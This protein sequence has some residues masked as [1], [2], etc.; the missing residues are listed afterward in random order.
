MRHQSTSAVTPTSIVTSP[1]HE[2]APTTDTEVMRIWVA[3]PIQ[4]TPRDTTSPQRLRFQA[5]SLEGKRCPRNNPVPRN[6]SPASLGNQTRKPALPAHQPAP[7][8]TQPA[9]LGDL[10]GNEKPWAPPIP[11][12]KGS[13]K[14]ANLR[15]LNA[16]TEL[17]RDRPPGGR[18]A[19]RADARSHATVPTAHRSSHGCNC[20]RSH[21]PRCGTLATH[22]SARVYATRDGAAQSSPDGPR[23]VF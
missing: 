3:R 21:G 11:Q 1:R 7:R 4:K 16:A 13:L 14:R 5:I 6:A 9:S 15:R 12:A 19:Y 20:V 10:A 17:T 2:L 18:V 22:P 23:G 8:E